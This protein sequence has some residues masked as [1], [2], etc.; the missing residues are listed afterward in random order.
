[1]DG[2]RALL[3]EQ[4][5]QY[6]HYRALDRRRILEPNFEDLPSEREI[7]RINCIIGAQCPD[8]IVLCQTQQFYVV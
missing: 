1:M 3:P 5:G 7:F 4:E 2:E 6:R 8:K